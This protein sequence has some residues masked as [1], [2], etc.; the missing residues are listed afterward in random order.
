MDARNGIAA[1]VRPTGY[2]GRRARFGLA[3]VSPT[4]L[5]IAL[6][7]VVPFFWT[8]FLSVTDIRLIDL[9]YAH[10]LN[11]D[12]TLGNFAQ[13]LTSSVFWESVTATIA[14]RKIVV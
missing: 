4:F 8:L 5:V 2:A 12:Y 10:L 11:A 14:D 6:V 1:L 13:V 3:L 7:V 9:P